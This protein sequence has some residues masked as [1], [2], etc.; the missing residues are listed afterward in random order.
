MH[1][2]PRMR[3]T[4]HL[5]LPL[6]NARRLRSAGLVAPRKS[7]RTAKG[8]AGWGRRI[9]GAIAEAG[10]ILDTLAFEGEGGSLDLWFFGQ[11]PADAVRKVLRL[12]RSLAR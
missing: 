3:A 11:D 7:P 10:T 1:A 12:G 9:K 2:D 5:K 4:I 8:E 6:R